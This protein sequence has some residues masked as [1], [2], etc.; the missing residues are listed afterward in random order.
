MSTLIDSLSWSSLRLE[1]PDIPWN[2]LD[3]MAAAA[4][5]H[6][7]RQH[8]VNMAT[9][10][11]DRRYAGDE[12]PCRDLTHLAVS[13]IFAL[14]AEWMGDRGCREAAEFL[15]H[16]LYRASE[17]ED[18]FTLSVAAQAAGQLGPA[19]VRPALDLA[20]SIGPKQRCWGHLLELLRQAEDADEPT[21]EAV[22]R[23]CRRVIQESPDRFT[24][25][26]SIIQPVWL[27]A[28]LQDTDSLPML[29]SIH[30]RSK[31][32]ELKTVI[33]VIGVLEECPDRDVPLIAPAME[34]PVEKWLPERIDE[35]RKKPENQ[36]DEDEPPEEESTDKRHD[37]ILHIV[38]GSDLRPILPTATRAQNKGF[39]YSVP[40]KIGRNAPCPCGSGRK[41]KKC[42]G[43]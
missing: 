41:Y 16:S 15:L 22:I 31:C 23:W 40:R 12:A 21:Y 9:R 34:I 19:V 27:L 29:R 13:A 4:D 18:D 10:S 30:A 43:R 36:D 25:Y 28:I 7:V 5:A 39:D 42:C 24:R 32:P 14:A 2:D 37:G 8:L 26:S 38:E 6:E 11:L 33:E 20:Q 3:E 1:G 35:S 17:A